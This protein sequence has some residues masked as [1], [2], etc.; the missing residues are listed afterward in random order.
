M[1]HRLPFM[2]L[3]SDRAANAH[4]QNRL[5]GLLTSYELVLGSQHGATMALTDAA[6]VLRLAQRVAAMAMIDDAFEAAYWATE[7][8]TNRRANATPT[9]CSQCLLD[10]LKV[11]AC[12]AKFWQNGHSPRQIVTDSAAALAALRRRSAAQAAVASESM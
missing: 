4:L 2:A 12:G 6:T 11:V 10:Y 5:Y 3:A 1:D 7:T 9:R 8:A